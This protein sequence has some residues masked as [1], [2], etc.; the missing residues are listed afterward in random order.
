M[1]TKIIRVNYYQ[2]YNTEQG[3]SLIPYPS[4]KNNGSCFW[5]FINV[6]TKD[7]FMLINDISQH[8][9]RTNPTYNTSR[10]LIS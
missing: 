3:V 7:K 5:S 8:Q 4:G 1:F 10:L 9:W 2:I 6:I